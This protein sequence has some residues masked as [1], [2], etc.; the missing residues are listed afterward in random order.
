MRGATV[1]GTLRDSSD[2]LPFTQKEV[3]TSSCFFF[4]L[5]RQWLYPWSVTGKCGQS[6]VRSSGGIVLLSP[7][8]LEL[9]ELHLQGLLASAEG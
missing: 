5:K 4:A 1:P 8:L 9:S 2:G 7:P 6:S 3:G